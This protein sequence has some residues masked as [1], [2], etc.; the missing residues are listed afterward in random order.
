MSPLWVLTMGCPVL[1][2]PV[3]ILLSL[4]HPPG[5]PLG[6]GLA[7]VEPLGTGSG[8]ANAALAVALEE[9]LFPCRCHLALAE[10]LS[11]V[12]RSRDP[13]APAS[14]TCSSEIEMINVY[15]GEV[16]HQA[17]SSS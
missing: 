12:A 1:P 11:W 2:M 10:R 16:K 5:Q 3:A 8:S 14:T 4:Q 15:L 13:S 7:Q 6:T 17:L 9:S